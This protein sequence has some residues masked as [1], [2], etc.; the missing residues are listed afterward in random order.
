MPPWM[1]TTWTSVLPILFTS[2]APGEYINKRPHRLA[3]EEDAEYIASDGQRV[4][5]YLNNAFSELHADPALAERSNF[6]L[7]KWIIANEWW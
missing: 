6:D 1:A 4:G 5:P 7:A 3:R 2:E